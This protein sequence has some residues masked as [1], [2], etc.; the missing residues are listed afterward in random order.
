MVPNNLI[1]TGLNAELKSEKHRDPMD[2]SV[3]S[4]SA[5]DSGHLPIPENADQLRKGTA[6]IRD[7]RNLLAG[8]KNLT[9]I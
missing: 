4:C 7:G 8:K 1:M 3:V 9:I 6:N 2:I 5:A